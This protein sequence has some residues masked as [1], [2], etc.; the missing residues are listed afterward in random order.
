MRFREKVYYKSSDIYPQ[1]CKEGYVIG[2]SIEW[3]ASPG[4]STYHRAQ[5]FWIYH[6]AE[7]LNAWGSEQLTRGKLWNETEWLEECKKYPEYYIA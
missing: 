4:M 3:S 7:K 6:V 1:D 2:I 5:P